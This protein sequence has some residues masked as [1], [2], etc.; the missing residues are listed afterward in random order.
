MIGGANLKFR[1]NERFLLYSLIR[2]RVELVEAVRRRRAARGI[3]FF[4]R[5]A[6]SLPCVSYR[7][8]NSAKNASLIAIVAAH[9]AE[10]EHCKVCNR[11]S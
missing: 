7:V 2:K 5:A 9:T 8:E 6:R 10:N 4:S 3:F 1:E 11:L